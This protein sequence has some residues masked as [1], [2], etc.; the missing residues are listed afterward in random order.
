MDILVIRNGG[1]IQGPDILEP[2]LADT[3]AGV[4]RGRIA[5]DAASARAEETLDVY[6]RPGIQLGDLIEVHDALYGESWRGKV[7]GITHSL[8]LPSDSIPTTTL[9]IER[10]I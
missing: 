2:L 1:D 5:I 8:S 10:P 3:A 4:A 9:R 6:M 7:S